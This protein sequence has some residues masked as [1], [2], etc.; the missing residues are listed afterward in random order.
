MKL[1]PDMQFKLSVFHPF[2]GSFKSAKNAKLMAVGVFYYFYHIHFTIC[3][4]LCVC[5]VLLSLS[6]HFLFVFASSTDEKMVCLDPHYCQSS[7]DMSREDFPTEV[8]AVFP[9]AS[10]NCFRT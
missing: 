5:F 3:T 8:Y 9:F 7:V 10:T 6:C 2:S 4:L 1:I